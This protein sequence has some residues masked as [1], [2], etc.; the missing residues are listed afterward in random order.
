VCVIFCLGYSTCTNYN[1]ALYP[2]YDV[3]NPNDTVRE[4]PL[5]MTDDGYFVV[6][7]QFLMWVEDLKLEVQRLRKE[8]Q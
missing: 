8:I 4:N 7:Q 2:G 5:R 3:L 1:P 6:N